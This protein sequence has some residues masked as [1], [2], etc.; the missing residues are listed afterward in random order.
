MR[1]CI[2]T[3]L[4]VLPLIAQVASIRI[5]DFESCPV[6]YLVPR[7]FQTQCD[8]LDRKI[9]DEMMPVE[10]EPGSKYPLHQ[11]Q[12]LATKYMR[13]TP[14]IWTS[15]PWCMYSVQ[16]KEIICTFTSTIFAKG[17]G[18]SIV[19]QVEEE[20]LMV[21]A[22]ALKN[23][24]NH[25]WPSYA[26]PEKDDRFEMVPI[27]GK[28]L[29][30]RAKAIMRRGD[31]AQS[32]TPVL[33]VQDSVMQLELNTDEQNLPIMVGVHRLP[34]RTRKLFTDLWG[35]FGGNPYYDKI[36]TNAFNAALGDSN[37]FY[38][39]TYPETSVSVNG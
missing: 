17:R 35:H 10:P 37:V 7:A 9:T 36:N 2:S 12:F 15:E 11:S 31:A 28:G 22:P 30:M 8:P 13:T 24:R 16:I 29:G 14:D 6:P 27:P 32:Y 21:R 39:S 4:S 1:R 34:P 33:S 20:P 38:W 26:N 18:I 19:A 3:A 25:T 5:A 23:Q